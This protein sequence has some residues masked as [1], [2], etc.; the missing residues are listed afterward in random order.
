MAASPD[1]PKDRGMA[2]LF[3]LVLSHF[4]EPIVEDGPFRLLG[5]ILE[6]NPYLGR[7]VTGR[8]SS[9]AVRPNQP[10]KVLD[11]NGKLLGQGRATTVPPFRAPGRTVSAQA[12]R[13]AR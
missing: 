2:P 13:A 11:R 4:A 3:D 8:I 5:T 12:P 9:A 1:G 7:I 6:A 10:A